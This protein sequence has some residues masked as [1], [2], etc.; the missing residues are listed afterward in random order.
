MVQNERG[1]ALIVVLMVAVVLSLLAL[2][3]TM[4]SM[5][6]LR[7]SSE[8]EN[9]EK[10]LLIADAGL[11]EVR[12]SLRGDDL[13]VLLAAT[14]TIPK[15]I[16]DSS[17]PDSQ[18]PRPF[19]YRNPITLFEARNVDFD[20]PPSG[21]GTRTDRGWVTPPEGQ[22][23]GTGRYFAKLSD[24]QDDSDPLADSDGMVCLRVI[25]VQAA[26]PSEVQSYGSARKNAVAVI[27]AL[28]KRDTTFQLQSPLTIPALDVVTPFGGAKFKVDGYDHSSIWQSTDDIGSHDDEDLPDHPAVNVVYDDPP[29]NSSETVEDIIDSLKKNEKDNFTG[30][31]EP[32]S[33]VDGTVDVKA[34]PD[35]QKILDAR[36][37]EKFV[38]T[39]SLFADE[40]VAPGQQPKN[41]YGTAENPRTIVAEGDLK[42]T[43][44]ATGWGLLVVKGE[45]E[46]KGTFAYNG[47]ML[48]VGKGSLNIGGSASVLG[49]V[50]LA[51]IDPQTHELGTATFSDHGGGNDSAGIY[52]SS[53]KIAFALS[54]VPMR[55]ISWREI[56]PEVEP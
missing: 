22:A 40:K 55:T 39:V 6:D 15:Y 10:A 56:T 51:N 48:I 27:E 14:A 36:F 53:E 19:A 20:S 44:N 21:Y 1:A 37:L 11:E 47:M 34:D 7:I 41:G 26:A 54:Q 9:H 43:G 28:L 2:S 17:N 33:I 24:N 45:L 38:N 35:S 16:A 25:A 4:S 46:L 30:T 50:L 18:N 8:F 5:S 13:D 23:V 3:L 12:A 32:P 31:G 52:N 42:I 49:G 29:Q